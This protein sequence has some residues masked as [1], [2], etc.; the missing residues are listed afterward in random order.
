MLACP[1]DRSE[2]QFMVC[3]G[4]HVEASFQRRE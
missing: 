3:D 2:W 4:Y 1:W